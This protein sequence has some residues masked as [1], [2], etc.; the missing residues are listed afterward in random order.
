MWKYHCTRQDKT[1]QHLKMASYNIVKLIFEGTYGNIYKVKLQNQSSETFYALKRSNDFDAFD[2]CAPDILLERIAGQLKNNYLREVNELAT[3]YPSKQNEILIELANGSINTMQ[4]HVLLTHFQEIVCGIIKGIAAMH[5][6]DLIH[7]DIKMMNILYTMQQENGMQKVHI[8]LTDFGLL[9]FAMPGVKKNTTIVSE[10]YRHPLL[11]LIGMHSKYDYGPWVDVWATFIL[12][13]T[14]LINDYPFNIR[15]TRVRFRD[16]VKFHPSLNYDQLL[17]ILIKMKNGEKL[18]KIEEEKIKTPLNIEKLLTEYKVDLEQ[19]KNHEKLIDLLQKMSVLGNLQNRMTNYINHS[20]VR[21]GERMTFDT[22]KPKRLLC[23]SS[24][25]S[26]K[27]DYKKLIRIC[28]DTN[29]IEIAFFNNSIT[30]PVFIMGLDIFY[31][32]VYLQKNCDKN[33]NLLLT[34]FV[35]A[36]KILGDEIYF[37]DIKDDEFRELLMD[38]EKDICKVLEGNFV[39]MSIFPIICWATKKVKKYGLKRVVNYFQKVNFE[40]NDRKIM[41]YKF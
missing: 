31:R 35:F 23:C 17:T 3:I 27:I 8:S 25:N 34:C 10:C 22:L 36:A 11:V 24:S 9:R 29:T 2:E 4:R 37:S 20:Y 21:I 28:S 40:W 30:L 18:T 33:N 5:S 39:N 12:I 16:I 6:I 7:G 32:Y 26:N 15:N 19:I 38:L 41:A 14:L 13:L 1:R